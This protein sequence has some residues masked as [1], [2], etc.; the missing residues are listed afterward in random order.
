MSVAGTVPVNRAAAGDSELVAA[1]RAGDDEAFEEL[2]RRYR[3]QIAAFIR[4]VVRDHGRAEDVAQEAF[5]SALR[6]MRE[7]RGELQFKPWIYRIARNAAID[8]YRR[9][10]RADEVSYELHA[11]GAAATAGQLAG[12]GAPDTWVIDRERFQHVRGALDGL[13]E[14]H[15]RAIIMRE[16]EGLSYREIGSRLRLSP[17]AVESTLFRARRK[18][19]HEYEQL[20]TGRRCR[21]IVAVTARLAEGV[22]SARDRHR[23]SRHARRCGICRARARR[24][25]VEPL[26]AGSLARRAAA[27]LPLPALL[28]R[29]AGG[30]DP[31]SAQAAA[32][33]RDVAGVAGSPCVESAVHGA[34]KAVA[35]LAAGLAI[36][37]GGATLGGAG[38]LAVGGNRTPAGAAAPDAA[39]TVA[40][41]RGPRATNGTG[42]A[43]APPVVAER[44]AHS[45]GD[46][47]SA[48]E[49]TTRSR[50]ERAAVPDAAP[51]GRPGGDAANPSAP[52]RPGAPR[53]P[54]VGRRR[55]ATVLPPVN[56][57]QLPDLLEPVRPI[58]PRLLQPLEGMALP[59][60]GRTDAALGVRLPDVLGAAQ[61]PRGGGPP[62]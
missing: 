16:L 19:E 52:A 51:P 49:R 61:K 36:G 23:L 47:G 18:L 38:P 24:L 17:A 43:T 10:E 21:A 40:P 55:P 57:P 9:D 59:G 26:P 6:R 28:R 29:P 27:L 4:C 37:G 11:G 5:V 20:D 42:R 50:P 15:H 35:V 32:H 2:Y 62:P 25:G 48:P 54:Q 31:V 39:G 41:K 44:G 53:L 7:T 56:L 60:L 30:I 1:T 58:A 33:A 13:S 14:T 3:G 45:A 8:S 46:S 22:E 34:S 12:A